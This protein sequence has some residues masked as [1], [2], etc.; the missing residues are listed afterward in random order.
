MTLDVIVPGHKKATCISA[1]KRGKNTE[2]GLGHMKFSVFWEIGLQ[3]YILLDWLHIA[4]ILEVYNLTQPKGFRTKSTHLALKV[5]FL[6][7][8]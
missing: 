6:R 5:N 3:I 8:T 7:S 1:K 4:P 2:T